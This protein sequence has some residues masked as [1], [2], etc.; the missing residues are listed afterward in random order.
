MR[1]LFIFL[2]LL[3]FTTAINGQDDNDE[4]PQLPARLT[5]D[6]WARVTY[7]S[8]INLR[9]EPSTQKA[10][11]DVI[12]EGT[13]LEITDGPVCAEGFRWWG[14]EDGWL[15]EG[16]DEEYW[17]EPRGLIEVIE[18]EDGVERTY[19]VDENGEII[20]RADC[21]RPP[22]DYTQIE[23][24]SVTFNVRTVTMLQHANRLFLASGGTVRIEDKVV[25]GS[26]NVGVEASFGTH[27]GGG[28]ADLSVRSPVDFSIMTDEIPLLIDALRTAGFAAWL[29][30]TDELYPGSPIHIHAIAVGDEEHSEAARGQIDGEFGYL[31][32]YNGLP[33]E[34]GEPPLADLDG[35]P[36]ICQWMVEMGFEDLREL[37]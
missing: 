14:V 5:V 31:R 32:G 18:D 19:I 34:E 17:L 15:A 29:R 6:E 23:W 2:L 11:L 28:A 7:D 22:D 3:S 33:Q 36:V 13:L 25:Q 20:E 27:D 35:E 10:R 26:Y 37:E 16:S 9:P 4:C 30:R 24:G 12:G 1:Q 8:Y 21:M